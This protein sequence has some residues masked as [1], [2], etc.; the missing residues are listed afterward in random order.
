MSKKE[1][2]TKKSSAKEK[3]KGSKM[4]TLMLIVCSL[5]MIVFWQMT[6]VMFVVGM[7]PSCVAFYVDRT[8]SHTLFHTVMPCNLA[9]VLPFIAELIATGNKT[10][11]MQMMLGDVSVVLMMYSSAALGWL[12][13]YG[14]PMFAGFVINALNERQIARVKHT[15]NKLV[16]E[17]G[18]EVTRINADF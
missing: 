7:L 14:S 4:L 5:A 17:W 2:K 6:Y 13:V 3:K 11:S 9:G 8:Q 10:S 16:K 18:N 12:L 15:Q 1:K